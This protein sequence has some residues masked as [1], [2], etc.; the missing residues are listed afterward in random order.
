VYTTLDPALQRAAVVALAEGAAAVEQRPGYSNPTYERRAAGRT[1]YL[2][3]A[4]VAIDPQTGDV[5]ALVGGRNYQDS[6]FNRAVNGMRQP[7]SSFKPFV[8]AR[9]ILDSIPANAIVPDTLLDV[10]YDQQVYRPRNA[11]GAFLGNL[12]LR[13]A[14]TKSRN[15]VAV[16]LWLRTGADSV[17]A[18]AQRFGLTSPIAPY[19]SSAVGASVVQPLNF[20]AAYTAFANLGTPV[21]P[22]FISRVDDRAGRTLWAPSSHV[23]PPAI[24]PGVAFIVRDMMRDVVERGTAMAVRR[25]IPPEVPVAGKTGTTDDNTDVWF[26]GITPDIVA[27]VWLGLDKPRP[28]A[29]H[30]V[31]G[32]SLAAPI[33]AQML[34]RAGYT[35]PAGSWEPPP[36]LVTAELDRE[37]GKPADAA[38]PAERRYTEYFVPGTEP[39]ALHLDARRLFM[40]GPLPF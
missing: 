32:G 13:E 26:V 23:L 33:F 16:Q 35:H 1:D 12:T 4:I 28:I 3:G 9:A 38:T 8:Y 17:I 6:P 25:Y 2:Q 21:E 27:G 18:L 29:E 19:P 34:A 24:D 36:G 15:P 5:R 14:I 30:G 22:R 37:T 20:I 31:A 11:D 10:R 7:G 39:V 40:L